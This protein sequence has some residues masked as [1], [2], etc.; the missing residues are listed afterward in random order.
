MFP[1]FAGAGVA[2]GV[3]VA[4]APQPTPAFKLTEDAV[5]SKFFA[6]CAAASASAATEATEED[7]MESECELGSESA[8]PEEISRARGGRRGFRRA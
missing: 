8:E 3:P 1:L 4:A 6:A 2:A 7:E 5:L